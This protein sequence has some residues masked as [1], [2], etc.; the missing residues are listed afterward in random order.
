MNTPYVSI[1]IPIF[2][3]EENIPVLWERLS[4]V[5]LEHFPRRGPGLGGGLHRRWQPG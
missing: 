4:R 3:E 5:L 1:V 2:N